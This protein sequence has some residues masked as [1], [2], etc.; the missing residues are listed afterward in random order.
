MSAYS[1]DHVRLAEA[2]IFASTDPVPTRQLAALL[3]EDVAA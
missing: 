2:L 3:P 1:D